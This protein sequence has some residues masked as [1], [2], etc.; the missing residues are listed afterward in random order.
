MRD[1]EAT[2]QLYEKLKQYLGTTII[3]VVIHLPIWKEPLYKLWLSESN[4]FLN[5]LNENKIKDLKILVIW[6]L[7]FKRLKLEEI[8]ILSDTFKNYPWLISSVWFCFP[9]PGIYWKHYIDYTDRINMLPIV[10]EFLSKCKAEWVDTFTD[11]IMWCILKDAHDKWFFKWDDVLYNS[12]LDGIVP[13]TKYYEIH[14]WMDGKWF[15]INSLSWTSYTNTDIEIYKY[16]SFK[17]LEYFLEKKALWLLSKKQFPSKCIDCKQFLI[18]CRGDH[19]NL[20]SQLEK[21]NGNKI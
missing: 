1:V 7:W 11:F 8:S 14:I 21:N 19:F 3:R 5:Y 10:I 4:I 13:T 18:K 17:N 20:I 15:L 12:M 2:H 6:V 9:H 16:G